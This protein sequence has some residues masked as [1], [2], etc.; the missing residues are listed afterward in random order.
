[1]IH[2]ANNPNPTNPRREARSPV[3]LL[4]GYFNPPW[5]LGARA[6]AQ[7]PARSDDGGL[8]E[9]FVVDD[10]VVAEW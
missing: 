5:I 7:M 1:M 4:N 2:Q 3:Q 10:A 9:R 8:H 6:Q